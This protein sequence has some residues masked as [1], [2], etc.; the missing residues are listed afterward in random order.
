MG[1]A[2]ARWPRR[3]AMTVMGSAAGSG[4]GERDKESEDDGDAAPSTSMV[5]PMLSRRAN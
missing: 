2:T 5:T 4:D 3:A 1:S